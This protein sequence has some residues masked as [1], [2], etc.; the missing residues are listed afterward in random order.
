[1]NY[2]IKD[3]ES[4]KIKRDLLHGYSQS[5]V[6][7]ILT[8]VKEDYYAMACENNDLRNDVAMMQETVQHYKT[9]EES[10]Q[11]TLIIAHKTSESIKLNAMDKAA[12]ILREA[13]LKARKIID[14]AELQVKKIR[15]EY[16][17][18][19]N[20]LSCYKVKSQS[21][22]NSLQDMLKTPFESSAE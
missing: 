21:L 19:K 11:H 2:T 15:Q 12:N 9:I 20:S 16:E 1:M 13:D 22:L 7:R 14:D 17:G 10:L 3:L 6:E 5:Q 8:R 18:I 4:L